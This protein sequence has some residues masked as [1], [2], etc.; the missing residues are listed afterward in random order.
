MGLAKGARQLA[1][2]ARSK[3]RR[4]RK[5][6]SGRPL[7]EDLVT[8]KTDQ[9]IVVAREGFFHDRSSL[10][11]LIEKVAG[12]RRMVEVGSL[13]GFS[14][15]IFARHF[16]EVHSVDPYSAGYD[17]HDRNSE[18]FRLRLARDL[19]TI[20]FLDEPSVTQYRES[21]DV[22]CERFDDG[23]LDLVYL[24]GS[25]T[26]E[27]VAR[28]IRCWKPKVRP[29]GSLAGDDYEWKGVSRAVKENLSDFVVVEGRWVSRIGGDEADS[30]AISRP[31]VP[32]MAPP[33]AAK[34]DAK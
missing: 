12:R 15:K 16:E 29:G 19:F 11:A 22:A 21:S 17:V 24:D 28:D 6:Q 23:S 25:H 14:T 2:S 7:R 34:G 10:L 8:L 13:A 18:W 27:D 32:V 5:A 26:Y 9:R 1:K 3:L 30:S 4:L 20:R 31:Q 33:S